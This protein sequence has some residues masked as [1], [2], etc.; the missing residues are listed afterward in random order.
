MKKTLI[1][2]AAGSLTFAAA[3]VAAIEL[4]LGTT[5]QFH[6]ETS[7]NVENRK[8]RRGPR[9]DR[10]GRYVEPR[11]VTRNDRVWRG[12]DGR[13]YCRRDNGTTGLIIGA[14]VG[15]LAG[16]EIARDRTLGAIVGA[17]AGGLL[18]REID[19]GSLS[20]R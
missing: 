16:R 6:S 14:G 8:D 7:V 5:H 20:C 9:Y 17:A 2:I 12:N 3:P 1:A 15:A 19:R 13:Y 11:R 4:P 18:G 10:H